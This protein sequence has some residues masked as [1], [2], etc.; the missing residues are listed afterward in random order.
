L[1]ITNDLARAITIANRALTCLFDI[2][3]LTV[4]ILLR[5]V[6]GKHGVAGT[7]T[8]PYVDL[9]LAIRSAKPLLQTSGAFNC[10]PLRDC[11]G[12]QF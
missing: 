9:Y 6:N 8:P 11:Q 7:R 4:K 1:Y 10:Q 3:H 5:P 12:E 2:E